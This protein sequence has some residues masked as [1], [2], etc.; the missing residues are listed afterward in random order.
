MGPPP[1][2][3]PAGPH[4]SALLFHAQGVRI[5]TLG[6]FDIIQKRIQAGDTAVI[7]QWPV[8]HL[9]TN[10]INTHHL[11]DSKG[12]LPGKAVDETLLAAR[13]GH[14]GHRLRTQKPGPWSQ[15]KAGAIWVMA[16]MSSAWGRCVKGRWVTDTIPSV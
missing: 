4:P 3:P 13:P 8:F 11:V 1:A 12:S 5:P 2:L 16:A 7:L 10:L 9:A 14:T 15:P 6:S